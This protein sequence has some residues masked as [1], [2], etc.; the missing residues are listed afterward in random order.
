MWMEDWQRIPFRFKASQELAGSAA[1]A[2]VTIFV[3]P[4]I[5]GELK[6]PFLFEKE[7]FEGDV[8]LSNGKRKRAEATGYLYN[9]IF[10]SYSHADK[11]VVRACRNVCRAL[12]FE[13]LLDLDTLRS[14]ERFDKALMRNI[15]DSDIFQLFWSAR[16]AK[17]DYVR[18]EW[19]HALKQRRG[20][21][22]VRPVYWEEPLVNPPRELSKFH[23][24]YVPL[25][26]MED[27]DY[28]P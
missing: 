8:F 16:S 21:G 22:F 28:L 12:G 7:D 23:F 19:K 2:K 25:P 13:F 4:L 3:G 6:I 11:S 14:G 1:N 15:E 24:A 9:K 27:S 5:V 18:Q 26:K 17:S 10:P 20:D